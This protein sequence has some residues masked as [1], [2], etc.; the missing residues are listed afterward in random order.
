MVELLKRRRFCYIFNTG[1]AWLSRRRIFAAF[2]LFSRGA[3]LI[4]FIL[5]V[6][7]SAL[8]ADNAAVLSSPPIFEHLLAEGHAAEAA[9]QPE[10]ALV[11]FRHALEQRPDDARLLQAISKQLS[12]ELDHVPDKAQRLTI[13]REA[14]ETA[15][16]AVRLAPKDSLCLVAVA[17]CEGKLARDADVRERIEA[18]R[19]VKRWAE[20]A[21]QI[22]PKSEW[23]EHVL[24]MWNLEVAQ[25]S[26]TKRAL[27]RMF[28]GDV[29]EG[30]F[31]EAVNHL[32][33]SVEL[34]QPVALH[35]LA[36]GFA[37]SKTGDSAAAR[38][39]WQRGLDLPSHDLPDETAKAQARD[40]MAKS[41]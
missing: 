16:R 21:L 41:D 14:L 19:E 23:A 3:I 13:E 2:V 36:L 37:Y 4:G 38:V 11:F 15:Q 25:I 18:S 34:G 31:A 6:S 28:Y 26:P 20:A 35:H 30:S 29:P 1:V 8:W 7:L 33:R 32:R 22:D 24:G 9:F 39:E 17:V 12:D 10:R 27:A 40:A 5:A